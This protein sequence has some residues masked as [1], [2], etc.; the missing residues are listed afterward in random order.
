MSKDRAVTASNLGAWLIKGSVQVRPAAE[1]RGRVATVTSWCLHPSYRVDLVRPGQP[2][3]F[4]ISGADPQNPAGIYAQG[5]TTGVCVPDG[6]PAE[7][8]RSQARMPVRLRPLTAPILREQLMSVPALAG[9]EVIRMAAGSNP[10]YLDV[11]QLDSL[12]ASFPEVFAG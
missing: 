10:S 11:D 5:V 8:G 9:I 1:L 12:A 7:R 2:V 4:W 3:L 6:E